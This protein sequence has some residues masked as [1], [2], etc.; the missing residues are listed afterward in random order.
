[1]EV[2]NKKDKKTD[3]EKEVHKGFKRLQEFASDMPRNE[4]WMIYEFCDY[5][6]F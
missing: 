5:H 3:E 4:L 6:L 1:M 2:L